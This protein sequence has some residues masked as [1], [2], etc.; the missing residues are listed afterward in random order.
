[1]V[2]L[3]PAVRGAGAPAPELSVIILAGRVRERAAASLRSV[4]AQQLRGGLEVLLVEAGGGEPAPLAGSDDPRVR[5]LRPA[6]PASIGTVRAGA[7][8]EARAPLVAFLEEHCVAAPGWAAA[9]LEAHRQGWDGVSPEVHNANPGVAWS[10]LVALLNYLEY[11][12]PARPGDRALLVGNNSSYRR[13][14]LLSYAADLAPLLGSEPV[15]AWKMRADGHRIGAAPAARIHHL[16]EVTVESVCRGYV[17]WNRCLGAT[18]ARVF[19]WST[20]HRI[21]RIVATPAVPVWRTARLLFAVGRKRRRELPFLLA[22]APVAFLFYAAAA[23]G[24][25]VGLALGAGDA[26]ERFL[27]YETGERRGRDD[28]E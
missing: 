1:M 7:V 27:A 20:A 14:L 9:L 25:A 19:A 13:D 6:L 4:L 8:R 11:S 3:D 26:G 24:E 22:T 5:V 12:P 18:R 15:L 2:S 10:D 16:N 21:A 23:A 28:R 17:L